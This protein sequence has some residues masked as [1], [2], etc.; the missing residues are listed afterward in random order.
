MDLILC[1]IELMLQTQLSMARRKVLENAQIYAW[2]AITKEHRREAN[3]HPLDLQPS[4][5]PL[6]HKKQNF[7]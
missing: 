4:I 5:L 2:R 7:K 3:H 6:H 1:S